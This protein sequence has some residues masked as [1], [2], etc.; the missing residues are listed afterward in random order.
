MTKKAIVNKV[1]DP[2]NSN[3]GNVGIALVKAAKKDG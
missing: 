2:K 3:I 1:M